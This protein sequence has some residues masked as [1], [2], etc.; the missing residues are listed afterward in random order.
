RTT[1]V[2]HEGHGDHHGRDDLDGRPDHRAHGE[3]HEHAEHGEHGGHLEHGPSA[4]VIRP[5][6]VGAA[7]LTV[8]LFLISMVPA[9]QFPHWGWAALALATPVTFWAAWPFHAAAARAAR[10]G[11]S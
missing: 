8:P 5:R 7:V 6:L 10:H 4:D 3:H 1:P 9:L 11:A 2:E